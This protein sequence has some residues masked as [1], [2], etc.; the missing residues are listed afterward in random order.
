MSNSMRTSLALWVLAPFLG[1][2]SACTHLERRAQRIDFDE[3]LAR[4]DG[5]LRER[6][7]PGRLEEALAILDE[8]ALDMG[9]DPRLL[10]RRARARYA[11][12]Y[13]YPGEDPPPL[14]LFEDGRETAWRCIYQDPS[15]EGALYSTGGQI[16]T[17]VAERIGE[18]HELCALWLVANWC[19]WLALRDPAGL[20]IDLQPLQILADRTVEISQ[21][22]RRA[23]ALGFAGV[24]RALTP[25]AFAPD[26]DE[27]RGLLLRAIEQE[28]D[29]LTFQ[30]DLAQ[31]V[32]GP[33]EDGVR[34]REVLEGVLSTPVETGGRFTLENRR[35]HQR[36]R[37]LLEASP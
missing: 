32:Y 8:L 2:L 37:A 33:L 1:T 19:R 11:Q 23:Q 12:G 13:G 26:L 7:L 9:E 36:A 4:V 20:A 34:Y 22:G 28:P 30:V 14:R 29:N 3:R 21:A 35:A 10:S 17:A 31:Y 25:S 5:L 6:H 27:A 15:F 24:S 18:E 16:G